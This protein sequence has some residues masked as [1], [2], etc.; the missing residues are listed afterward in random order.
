LSILPPKRHLSI[1]FL[2]LGNFR[3]I[4]LRNFLLILTH[5]RTLSIFFRKKE[6]ACRINATDPFAIFGWWWQAPTHL[7][8]LLLWQALP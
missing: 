8:R 3:L 7:P 2:L 6:R 5:V 1:L 4:F